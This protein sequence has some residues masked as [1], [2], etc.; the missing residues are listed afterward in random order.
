MN[1]PDLFYS[2]LKILGSLERRGVEYV[3]VGGFAVILHG[4]ARL[5]SDIDL[6]VKPDEENMERERKALK[7]VFPTDS[8]IDLL[9]LVDP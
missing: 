7:D 5:T 8:E 3:L 9:A 4:L 6:F 1:L 2:F